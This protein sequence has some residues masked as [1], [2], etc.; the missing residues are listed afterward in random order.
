ME[1]LNVYYIA[2]EVKENKKNIF[3]LAYGFIQIH[4]LGYG[5]WEFLG[6]K[7]STYDINLIVE[8]YSLKYE[9]IRVLK[10]DADLYGT[11]ML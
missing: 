7:S 3:Y 11:E 6:M 8:K 1:D 2:N 4:S 9:T 5:I 10:F